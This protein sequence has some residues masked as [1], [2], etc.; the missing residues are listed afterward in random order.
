MNEVFV[1]E[2]RRTPFGSFL[3]SLSGLGAAE[4]GAR[5]IKGLIEKSGIPAEAVDEVIL[6]QVLQG[7]A[8]QSPA[9]QASRNAGL[10]DSVHALTVNKVCGSGLKAIMLGADSIR[11]GDSEVVV[12]GG[13][14]N[15]SLAPY[16]LPKARTGYRM[17]KG[18]IQDMMVY[19]GLT[20]PWTGR[21]MGEIAD[22]SAEKHGLGRAE[23]D[24]F[25]RRSYELA[26]A[27]I[28]GGIFAEELVPVLIATKKGEER[29]ERDE[30]P[31]KVDFSRMATLRP[32]FSPTGSITAANAS[33]ISDGAAAILLA[34]EAA[35]KT[36]KL[37]VKARLVA[38]A[39]E[40]RHPDDFPGAPVGAIRKA[41]ARAGL[42]VADIDLFEINEAFAS[43]ALLAMKELEIPA[44]RV[45]VNGGACAIG[46]PI[47]AS[48]GRLAATLVRELGRRG[49]R[50]GLATLC[51]GG[52]EAVAAIFER[53]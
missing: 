45:N 3:G 44:D 32:V 18:E 37:K 10:P 53:A 51:I 39:T 49:K 50:Y 24:A 16:L 21:H 8:G 35:V 7:G 2:G 31:F 42:R 48:G 19:D 20:D 27:A 5:V 14:E 38:A 46:H 15:M 33:S 40:S 30:E 1:V 12:A 13:M 29:I 9:R 25:A 23:Q 34:S 6:G 36:H 41:L 28:E 17:G 43:V 11:L 4:L 52:G 47:G 22:A 26:Q